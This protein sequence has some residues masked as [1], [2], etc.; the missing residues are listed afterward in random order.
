MLKCRINN[1]VSKRIEES[2]PKLSEN[3]L[4]SFIMQPL[5]WPEDLITDTYV[6]RSSIE[7]K[8]KGIYFFIIR[9]P[10][11]SSPTSEEVWFGLTNTRYNFYFPSPEI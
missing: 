1:E 5:R 4:Y 8:T 9:F 2:L 3:S 10:E 6:I 7:C 11:T